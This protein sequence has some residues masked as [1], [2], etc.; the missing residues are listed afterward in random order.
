MGRKTTNILTD[1]DFDED[2]KMTHCPQCATP[3]TVPG[4]LG[5]HRNSIG[6][7]CLDSRGVWHVKGRLI[8]K[9]IG[10]YNLD[11]LYAAED[12]KDSKQ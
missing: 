7:V 11:E 5:A 12:V 8:G 9:P 3:L 4:V 2:I 10:G 1:I 6:D